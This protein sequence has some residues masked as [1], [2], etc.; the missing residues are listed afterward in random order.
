M[1]K[2]IEELAELDELSKE[3]S[4]AI[5]GDDWPSIRQYVYSKD[6]SAIA[7]LTPI[8]S[9]CAAQG[10]I[11]AQ[12]ILDEAASY[13]ADLARRMERRVKSQNMPIA[14]GGGIATASLGIGKVLEEKLGRK[15]A[16]NSHDHSLTAAKLGLN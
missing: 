8:I 13:L 2:E 5:G 4:K 9:K 14:F 7:S 15:I 6:R 1:M 11:S 3:L 16:V 10:S 12:V